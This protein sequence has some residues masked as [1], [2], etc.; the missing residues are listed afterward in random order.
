MKHKRSSIQKTVELCFGKWPIQFAIILA[1]MT[2]VLCLAFLELVSLHR[3]PTDAYFTINSSPS[4]AV[5][6]LLGLLLSLDM[7]VKYAITIQADANY[8]CNRDLFRLTQMNMGAKANWK[9][10][11][12]KPPSDSDD[13][14]CLLTNKMAMENENI[15]FLLVNRAQSAYLG[16]SVMDYAEEDTLRYYALWLVAITHIFI[17]PLYLVGFDDKYHIMVSSLMR[18]F[19]SYFLTLLLFRASYC[20]EQKAQERCIPYF[21]TLQTTLYPTTIY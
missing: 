7:T 20:A 11:A 14:K 18:S 2:S 8:K 21:N 5:A 12:E 19:I 4:D 3:G 13:I 16:N 15:F 9:S 1:G 17:E 6:I 10:S